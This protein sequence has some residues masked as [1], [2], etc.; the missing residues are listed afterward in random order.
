[1]PRWFYA[2]LAMRAFAVAAATQAAEPVAPGPGDPDT[3]WIY[4]CASSR[5]G[6]SCPTGAG[7]ARPATGQATTATRREIGTT[8]GMMSAM[9]VTKLT[10]HLRRVLLGNQQAQALFYEYSTME[11]P[12]GSGFA[13]N[14]GLGTLSCQVSGMKLEYSGPPKS[15]GH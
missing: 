9:H 1:M 4:S 7:G 12:T 8:G 5:C 3:E 6:F 11:A 13:I 14:T 15:Q 10:I 2:T